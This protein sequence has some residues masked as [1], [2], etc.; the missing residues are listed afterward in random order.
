VTDNIPVSQDSVVTDRRFLLL[1]ISRI[2]YVLILILL[3]YVLVPW[4]QLTALLTSALPPEIIQSVLYTTIQKLFFFLIAS[5]L[6]FQL[7]RVLD[8]FLSQQV[9]QH[10]II[11]S[12][13]DG[14]R[15]DADSSIRTSIERLNIEPQ[16]MAA[17]EAPSEFEPQILSSEKV[18]RNFRVRMRNEYRRLRSISTRN[19]SIGIG[20]SFAALFFIAYPLLFAAAVQDSAIRPE[21][22]TSAAFNWLARYYVPRLAVGLLLQFVGFFFLRLYVANEQDIKH[23]SNEITN[24][25]AKMM[26]LLVAQERNDKSLFKALIDSLAKTE[27]NFVIKRK[28]RTILDDEDRKYNDLKDVIQSFTRAVIQPLRGKGRE[29]S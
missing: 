3:A 21:Q 2:G 4:E 28:D 6:L 20:F 7:R 26:G 12:A 11:Q 14:H 22:E 29:Q 5:F 23:N 16:T 18:F 13:P 24:L 15:A 17:D 19:L 8:D 10:V 9:P 27:R 25:E 1:R